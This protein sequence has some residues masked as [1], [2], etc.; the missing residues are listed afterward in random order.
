MQKKR[1]L[2]PYGTFFTAF[3]VALVGLGLVTITVTKSRGEPAP[4]KH[5]W[6]AGVVVRGNGHNTV[7]TPVWY[8][9]KVWPTQAEC[10][11]AIKPADEGGDEQFN[12]TVE[13]YLAEEKSIHY[14]DPTFSYDPPDCYTFDGPGQ[15]V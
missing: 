9:N 5:G 14:G 12:T 7:G 10:L 11:A 1:R 6:A 3:A 15:R 2:F 4:V 8:P 13:N